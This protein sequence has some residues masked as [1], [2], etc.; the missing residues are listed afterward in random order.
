MESLKINYFER[1][2]YLTEEGVELI[3]E[4]I[5]LTKPYERSI[6]LVVVE[7]PKGYS[8]YRVGTGLFFSGGRGGR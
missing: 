5:P 6:Y 2:T 3:V 4:R 7:E 8:Q 1:L